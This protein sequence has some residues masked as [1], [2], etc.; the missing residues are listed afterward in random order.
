MSVITCSRC[1]KYLCDIDSKIKGQA[2]L[3]CDRCGTVNY[4]I[5]PYKIKSQGRKRSI[6]YEK[7]QFID[8]DDD[9]EMPF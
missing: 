5:N 9:E 8:E 1:K 4:Y 2:E 6:L 3:V 7:L